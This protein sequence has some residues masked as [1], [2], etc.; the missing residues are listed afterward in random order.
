MAIP[1]FKSLDL[2]GK[3]LRPE[4]VRHHAVVIAFMLCTFLICVRVASQS[5]SS[6]GGGTQVVFYSLNGFKNSVSAAM[7]NTSLSALFN[8]L[9]FV[10]NIAQLPLS[11]KTGGVGFSYTPYLPFLPLDSSSNFQVNLEAYYVFGEN[12]YKPSTEKLA[13]IYECY[14]TNTS[15]IRDIRGRI[16]SYKESGY[17]LRR[18]A[19]SLKAGY[20]SRGTILGMDE[21]R[22]RLGQ[23]TPFDFNIALGYSINMLD[24]FSV[25]LVLRYIQSTI[26]SAENTAAFGSG[27]VQQISASSF[28]GDIHL[29][30]DIGLKDHERGGIT[31][32][33]ILA[34]IGTKVDFSNGIVGYQPAY[35][36]IGASF[37]NIYSKQHAFHYTFDFKKSLVHDLPAKQ[38]LTA[39]NL[40]MYASLSVEQSMMQSLQSWNNFTMNAGFQYIY[41]EML[42]SRLG[43]ELEKTPF[44]VVYKPSLGV[45]ISLFR[46]LNVNFAYWLPFGQALTTLSHSFSLSASLEF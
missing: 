3:L 27:A 26:F 11:N 14:K 23:L 19:L 20:H 17:M 30:Y 35:I 32:S 10:N 44:E 12:Y 36:D 31:L 16:L 29:L 9:S 25:G 28:S 8:E 15:S 2:P 41:N 33:L 22:N 7:G 4:M 24:N 13:A 37:T 45:G 38:Y 21:N 43:F 6:R 40:K 46:K 18:Q 42:F 1:I 5:I 34:N 39:E